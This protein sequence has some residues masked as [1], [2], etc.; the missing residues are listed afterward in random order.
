MW[1]YAATY[2]GKALILV[3]TV[4]LANLLT[5]LDFGIVGI[6]L[7]V[8]AFLEVMQDLG[9][10]A[11]L[12]YQSDESAANT[13]FWLGMLIGISLFGLTFL[14]APVIATFFAEPSAVPIIR[15]LGLSFPLFA[16]RNIHDSLLRKQLA[17][18]QRFLPDMAQVFCKGGLSIILAALNFGA[19]SL[20]WGQVGGAA[21]SVVGYWIVNPWR[22]QWFFDPR[23]SRALLSYGT[24]IVAVNALAVVLAQS[25]YL[26]IGHYLGTEALGVY[27][28]AFRLPDLMVMQ[29][30][31]VI[32]QVMFPVYTRLR[33]DPNA[34]Q[35]GFLT[36][37]RYV[38]LITV[39]LSLG[40]ALVA[41]PFVQAFLPDAWTDAIPIMQAIA[42][43]TLF[44]SLGFNAGDV[45]KAQGRPGI[46]TKLSL[47]RAAILLPALW[48]ATTQGKSIV[49]VALTHVVVAFIGSALNLIVAARLL[50]VSFSALVETV[51]SAI[52]GGIMMAVAVLGLLIL[53]Q[54]TPPLVQLLAATVVGASVY[55]AAI[56]WIQRDVLQQAGQTLRG[57]LARR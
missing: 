51:R 42:I 6:A 50:N 44:L 7:T 46:L 26:L 37:T 28:W 34:L 1:T 47:V 24:S 3:S 25:D 27:T 17:F 8:I 38:A 32:A 13:A 10:G 36:T 11:A 12:I 9:I 14:A 56:W 52:I 54:T 55:A 49:I 41:K 5:K 18:K 19:W 33:D 39:P 29:F 30:C 21:L 20:V 40:L 22:P 57:A 31:V 53:L 2:G 15:V 23:T 4:I 16:L 35:T 45:Y 48:L 43:Y